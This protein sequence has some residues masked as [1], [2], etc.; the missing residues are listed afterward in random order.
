ML[1]VLI[2]TDSKPRTGEEVLGD[3]PELR[4]IVNLWFGNNADHRFK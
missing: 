3:N 1:D 4:L 2:I